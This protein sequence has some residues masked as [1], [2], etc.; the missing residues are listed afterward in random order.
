MAIAL[1]LAL[2]VVAL[3]AYFHFTT[4]RQRETMLVIAWILLLAPSLVFGAM[5]LLR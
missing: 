5:A 4:E 3:F 2:W 1:G